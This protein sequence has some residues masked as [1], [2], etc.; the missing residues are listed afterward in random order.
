M[1]VKVNEKVLTW[2]RQ[3]LNLSQ[4]IVAR[5]MGKKIEDI[6][7][8]EEGKDYP[9]YAQL[10]KLSYTIYKKPLAVFFFP[11]PPKNI[12]QQEKNFRTL[13]NEIYREIPTE[14]LEM[15]NKARIMQI[16]LQ[17]INI[18][19]R[20][21]ITDIYFNIKNNEFY[22][23]LRDVLNISIDLQKKAKN[24]SDAFEMWRSA[25]YECGIYVFKDAF[26][27]KNFSG[28]CLYDEHF[29]II[30][31]NNS[32]SFSRQIFTLFHELFHII[33]KTS[34]I[35]KTEDDYLTKLS[36]RNREIETLCNSFAGEF[37]V[38]NEILM[39]ELKGK[40]LNEKLISNVAKKY[41]VSREVIYRKLLN[42][43]K[44]SKEMYENIHNELNKE[45][46]RDNKNSKGG[47]YYSTQKAYL[48]DNYI[49]DVCQTYYSGKIDIYEVSNFLNV[50]IEGIPR[51][52]IMLK[53]GSR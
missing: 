20:I 27:E 52:G 14:I 22:E 17:E 42:L 31:I 6:Q 50:K 1:K 11:E 7:A 35:D 32:M 2:A 26:K 10:E 48:G 8:W 12:K 18:T 5:R 34:G 21:K 41:S 23:K 43:N 38:P 51:L 4:D 28:F 19:K 16:N 9:T 33:L 15:M 3:E 49:S 53:E 36:S 30:Y 40:E 13:N 29:P 25:F 44:I 46:Y 24:Y 45:I 37:L 39:E 47:N